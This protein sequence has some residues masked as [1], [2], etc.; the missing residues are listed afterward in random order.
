MNRHDLDELELGR[1]VG[2]H[3][4]IENDL[5]R[6]SRSTAIACRMF[7]GTPGKDWTDD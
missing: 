1:R 3:L 5:P 7:F 6:V 2:F 4:T